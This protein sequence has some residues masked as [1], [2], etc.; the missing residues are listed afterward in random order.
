ML[1]MGSQLSTRLALKSMVLAT[2]EM[3][4]EITIFALNYDRLV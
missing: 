2:W 3:G 4:L 1:G